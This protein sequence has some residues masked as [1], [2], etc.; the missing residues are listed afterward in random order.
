MQD[1]L[2]MDMDTLHNQNQNRKISLNSLEHSG[3]DSVQGE[4][5]WPLNRPQDVILFLGEGGNLPRPLRIG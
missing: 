1:F 3:T 5:F 4:D 2:S